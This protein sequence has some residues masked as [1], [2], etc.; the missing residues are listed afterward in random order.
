MNEE[1]KELYVSVDAVARYV[2]VY[3]DGRL[4]YQV[5]ATGQ[6]GGVR[7]D[8]NCGLE[9]KPTMAEPA[10][11]TLSAVGDRGLCREDLHRWLWCSV[12]G[13]IVVGDCLLH[14]T[15]QRRLGRSSKDSR[16]RTRGRSTETGGKG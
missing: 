13:F 8:A 6:H 5:V 11:H 12:I 4:A 1:I 10:S 3:N 2:A 15:L 16:A 14:A 9:I 7:L